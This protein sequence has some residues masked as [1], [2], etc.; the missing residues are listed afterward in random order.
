MW[1]R[2]KRCMDD[3]IGMAVDVNAFAKPW[4]I[5]S[6]MSLAEELEVRRRVLRGLPR[7]AAGFRARLRLCCFGLVQTFAARAAL[8]VLAGRAARHAA[9][10]RARL[11]GL[12]TLRNHLS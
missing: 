3:I 2:L 6:D 8:L 12:T 1:A 9:R 11:A 5:H 4:W 7:P 10:G